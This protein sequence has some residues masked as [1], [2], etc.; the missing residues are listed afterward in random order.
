[1]KKDRYQKK[2]KSDPLVLC[3]ETEEAM[4][5]LVINGS[6]K[7]KNSNTYK[8]TTAFVEG[9]KSKNEESLLIEELQV[10]QL[11]IKPCLGCFS[12]WKNTP[13]KCVIED[14]MK[15][16]LEKLLWADITLWSFPL[17]YFNVPGKLKMLI[18]RLLPM[19][20]PF[21][22]SG[23]ESG[24]HPSRY[25]MSKKRY[26]LI[27]TCGFYT[28][29]GNYDSV[30]SMFGHFLGKDN[31]E[32]IFCGQG[33]LF[34]VPELKDRT[35]EY[36]SF[37]KNAGAEYL[38]EKISDDTRK[39]LET[40]LFPREIFESMADASWGI[41]E[42]TGKKMD[43][44]LV[45]IKQMAALYNKNSYQGQEKVLEMDFTD[46]DKKYQILLK[47]DGSEVL[48]ENFK[49]A[50]T[51]IITPYTVWADIASGKLN[52]AEA[53]MKQMYRVEGDYDIIMRWND[54]FGGN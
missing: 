15:I 43:E 11:V 40:L 35:N 30:I 31:F 48:T 51:K 17:F 50:T 53:M 34:R 38:E 23:A 6:S 10:N 52:G 28:A 54:Y 12:C 32:T 45:F 49:D 25:D 8:L 33:E 16:V 24:G 41:D 18:D 7:G 14:D 42:S 47:E 2:E 46:V 29:K 1:M 37:V 44:T 36:L 9:L 39:Q 5:V 26:V 13:G 27:S 20:L 4:N 21:M 19:V 3:G 22:E